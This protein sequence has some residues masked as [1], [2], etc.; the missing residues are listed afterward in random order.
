MIFQANNA[1]YY[2]DN[3]AEAADFYRHVLGFR[4]AADYGFAQIL[5]VAPTSFLTLVDG[6]KGMHST[7]E[8]K[9]VTLA[10]ITDQVTEWYEYLVAQ[11]VPIRHERSPKA[12]KAHD[13]FVA[14]DPEGYFLE[15]E[16]FNPHPENVRM[17]PHLA[18]LTP[19]APL[20]TD[21]P[22]RP[23]NLTITATILWLYY[24]DVPRMQRLVEGLFGLNCIVDQGFAKVYPTSPTGFIGP[25]NAGEGLHPFSAEKAVTVSLWTDDLATWFERLEAEPDFRL[26]TEQ[27]EHADPRFS[28]IVGYDPE[29]YFIELNRFHAHA[30][31]RL[32]LELLLKADA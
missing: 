26:R 27:I 8:P 13:G 18:K 23:A 4:L 1:F 20:A 22:T 32:L 2:Y 12:G 19:L 11:G 9:T 14:L 15:F 29:G 5:Q 3:L 30:D 10:M 24:Q 7:S 21:P 6:A 31:N 28:A 25:V 17:L 16:C